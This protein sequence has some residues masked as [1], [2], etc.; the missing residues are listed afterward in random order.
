M[1]LPAPAAPHLLALVAVAAAVL[2]ALLGRFTRWPPPPERAR[3]GRHAATASTP[4]SALLV[5]AHPDDEAMFFA[6][7]ILALRRGGYRVRILCLSAGI[8]GPADGRT[9]RADEL[10][11]AAGRLGVAPNDVDVID[12]PDLR[13]GMTTHW[14]APLVAGYVKRAVE[15]ATTALVVTFDG[16]GVTGHVNHAATHAGVAL[17]AAGDHAPPCYALAS[18]AAARKFVGG[19]WDVALTLASHAVSSLLQSP[20]S[21]ADPVAAPRA[22]APRL[23][24]VVTTNPLASHAALGAHASQYAWWRVLFVAFSRY[25]W[26]NSLGLMN[27]PPPPQP[28]HGG[29]AE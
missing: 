18:V 26:V 7:T 17:Y 24:T 27:P 5:T 20:A 28:P 29:K 22:D 11:A 10:R 3:S 25:T 21:P 2:A 16:G 4:P 1:P 15:G 23:V 6:P 14:S 8:N 13:D 9:T 19:P 12:A